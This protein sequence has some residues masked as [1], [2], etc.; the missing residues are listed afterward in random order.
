MSK[1]KT[2]SKVLELGIVPVVRAESADQAIEFCKGL[3][4]QESTP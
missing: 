1:V 2:I 3:I 4:D